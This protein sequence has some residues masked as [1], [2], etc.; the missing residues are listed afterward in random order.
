[1][2]GDYSAPAAKVQVRGDGG[3]VAQGLKVDV[4]VFA[5]SSMNDGF[6]II[7]MERTMGKAD[8]G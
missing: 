4:R 1:M 3:C 5:L 8:Q 6:S 2:Q 7:K